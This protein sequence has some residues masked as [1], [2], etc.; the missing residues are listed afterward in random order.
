[1][2][3]NTHYTGQI[4]KMGFF[5]QMNDIISILIISI[6]AGVAAYLPSLFFKYPFIQLI[7]GGIA[8][9]AVYLTI[10][11][12]VKTDEMKEMT[13]LIFGRT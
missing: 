5:K 6:F 3:I 13:A 1:M 12:L 2:V 10:A 9:I 11:F 8:G 7:T 4:L